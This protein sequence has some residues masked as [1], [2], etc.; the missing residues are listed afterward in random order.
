MA[1]K[2][3]SIIIPYHDEGLPLLIQ[4]LMSI[5][6]QVG[7]DLDTLEVIVVSDGGE[8]L[9]LKRCH[10]L[11]PKLTIRYRY[12]KKLEEKGR[13]VSRMNIATGKFI[14][15]LDNDDEFYSDQVLANL[16]MSYCRKVIIKLL[17]GILWN[18]CNMMMAH[19]TYLI[20]VMISI[21]P[22]VNG[23]IGNFGTPPVEM[24]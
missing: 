14:T 2:I 13:P 6:G 3:V 22:V 4:T 24:A 15:F 10:E 17:W 11:M 20:V 8:R 16:L 12:H 9:K 1:S 21:M 19:N 7:V 23:S 5:N 18:R